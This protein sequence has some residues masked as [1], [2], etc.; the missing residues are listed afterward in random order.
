MSKSQK[1]TETQPHQVAIEA[2]QIPS[3]TL[4][5]AIMCLLIVFVAVWM[6]VQSQQ[7]VDQDVTA[8][9][10]EEAMLGF[11]DYAWHL[12]DEAAMG[13]VLIPAG[14]FTMG[15]NPALDRQAYENERWSSTRRQGTVELDDFY[16]GLFEV[17]N[18]QFRAF[19]A[20]NPNAASSLDAKAQ[21]DLPVTNITW[22]EALAYTR[23][24]QQKLL[25]SDYTPTELRDFLT[26]GGRVT[27]PSEAEWE[28][29]A[30]GSDGRI[31]P[32]GNQA[33]AE[34]AN[35]AAA[36]V[37]AVGSKACGECAYGLQDMSGNVWELTRS[38]LQSYP[39]DPTDDADNLGEDALWVMRGGSF[40]DGEANVRAAVRGGVDPSVRNDTIGFRVAISRH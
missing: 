38:P 4:G 11:L 29:A 31:F 18:A 17:T 33:S 12:P 3:R 1:G 21:G 13:F 35:Y 25:S 16:I 14:P 9:F 20:E 15:S 8:M 7:R 32:W 34:F 27:I 40:A 36:S 6:T 37:Q 2:Q 26:E 22:P 30:R 39:F 10:Q 24:L 19:L 23:W 28:K 5:L